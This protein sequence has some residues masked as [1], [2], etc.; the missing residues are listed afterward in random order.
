MPFR[1]PDPAAVAKAIRLA[2]LVPARPATGPTPPVVLFRVTGPDR[3]ARLLA[4][5]RRSG[6]PGAGFFPYGRGRTR[7]FLV[8]LPHPPAHLLDRWRGHVFAER[9]ANVWVEVGFDH[10]LAEV[11]QAPRGRRLLIPADGPWHNAPNAPFLPA[12]ARPAFAVAGHIAL[13]SAQAPAAVPVPARLRPAPTTDPAELWVL[14]GPAVERLH[15][16][17]RSADGR[18]VDDLD[19]AVSDA[20][21]VAVR[22]RRSRRGPPALALAAVPFVPLLKLPNV[23]LP[24]GAR[25]GPPVRRDVLRDWLC[26]PGRVTWLYPGAGGRFA[27]ESVPADAFRPLTEWVEYAS[28]PPGRPA[29]VRPTTDLFALEPFEVIEGSRRPPPLPRRGRPAE[30]ASARVD[31]ARPLRVVKGTAP[32]REPDVPPPA[33]DLAAVPASEALA[34]LREAERKF[35]DVDGPLDAPERRALWPRLAELAA[36]AGQDEDAGIGW[37]H[38]LWDGQSADLAR[39]WL[40]TEPPR[41]GNVEAISRG[42]E[43]RLAE[44]RG[45]AAWLVEAAARPAPPADVLASLPVVG[46]VLE[47]HDHRLPVRVAWLAWVAVS[48]LS[49]GDVLALTRA[50]DRI[51][52]DLLENGLRGDRD[53]PAF[54]RTGSSLDAAGGPGE[55]HR[56]LRLRERARDWCRGGTAIDRVLVDLT[57]AA[58]LARYGDA[59]AARGL[60][61]AAHLPTNADPYEE[62]VYRAYRERVGRLANREPATAPL[63]AEL[64]RA[65]DGLSAEHGGD[66]QRQ[67]AERF[68]QFSRILEPLDR[69]DPFRSARQHDQL[70]EALAEV[71]AFTGSGRKREK[72]AEQL[73]LRFRA[74]F[75]EHKD[76]RAAFRILQVAVPTGVRVGESFAL[77]V[78]GRVRPA[79]DR[80]AR[81]RDAGEL[82][83]RVRLL[84]DAVEVAAHFGRVAMVGPLLDGL[85]ALLEGVRGEVAG[86][87]V[88][89]LGGGGFRFLSRLG[90][91]DAAQALLSRLTDALTGGKSVAQLLKTPALNRGVMHPA[92]LRLAGGWFYFG[93]EE[94]ARLA[95]AAVRGEL[96]D[97]WM[98]PEPR[99]RLAADYATALGH[100][101]AD[102]A[103]DGFAELFDRLTVT[104]MGATGTIQ[105]LRVMEAVALATASEGF[106]ADARSRRWL[107]EDEYLVRRRIHRDV[108]AALGGAALGTQTP[109]L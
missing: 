49:G 15:D 84:Q 89:G 58:A 90:L 16:L 88:T 36:A 103:M 78:V 26:R 52:R 77:D 93:D 95:L 105:R 21:D 20:G 11:V 4:D 67:A 1:F 65:L 47:A 55:S 59:A 48:R 5:L 25:L 30:D 96:F 64:R 14:R 8:R 33:E 74:L 72:A 29:V 87:L 100:A 3:F 17:V 108:E 39:R 12:D 70:G 91:A 66:A 28:P 69:V 9:A 44:L 97:G 27:V 80:L 79:L 37:G 40:R 98:S 82:I 51:L 81:W 43:P 34:R 54:L 45:L 41:P 68:L 63:S 102:L 42:P 73:E 46:R 106:A 75:Q 57:F 71:G 6:A 24:A 56:L 32:E 83:D 35:L 76:P 2:E 109:Q 107:D 53:V 94:P 92:L 19:F 99:N 13:G 22:A 38:A 31:P 7:S 62:W 50:R 104:G 60:A 85:H 86:W 61:D 23:Y 18:V 101:P 10:P